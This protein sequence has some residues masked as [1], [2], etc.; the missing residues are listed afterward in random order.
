MATSEWLRKKPD[1]WSQYQWENLRT[2][3]SISYQLKCLND[4][5]DSVDVRT[6][7]ETI[8]GIVTETAWQVLRVIERNSGHYRDPNS[9]SH[10]GH[11]DGST[12]PWE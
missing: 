11:Y 4:K 6:S 7:Y 3:N 10:T 9:Y 1:D 8:D 5:L 12:P 2:L